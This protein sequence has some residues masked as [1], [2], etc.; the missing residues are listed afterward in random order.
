MK[1][2]EIWLDMAQRKLR[3][4]PNKEWN[5]IITWGLFYPSTIKRQLARGELFESYPKHIPNKRCSVW[6]YPSQEAWEKKIKPII[7]ELIITGR[8]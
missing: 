6:V 7:L 5:E 2:R 1:E 4:H 3:F 8:W